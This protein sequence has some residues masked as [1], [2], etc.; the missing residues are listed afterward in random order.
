MTI[1]FKAVINHKDVGTLM[2]EAETE[3]KSLAAANNLPLTNWSDTGILKNL[4]RPVMTIIAAMYDLL[5]DD[6]LTQFD[7]D[8]AKGIWVDAFLAELNTSRKIATFA[9]YNQT[10]NRQSGAGGNITIPKGAVVSTAE[11]VSGTVLQFTVKGNVVMLG[12][13]IATGTIST[14]GT[15]VTGVGTLA[16]VEFAIGDKITAQSQ[17]R[18]IQTITNATTFTVDSAFSSDLS[19]DTFTFKNESVLVPII[20]ERAGAAYN[21]EAGAINIMV[22]SIANIGTTS[23]ASGS[24]TVIARD[25]ETDAASIERYRNI[26]KSMSRAGTAPMYVSL[27]TEVANVIDVF[28]DESLPRGND[29]VDVYYTKT[30]GIPAFVAGTGTITGTTATAVVTGA[31]TKFLTELKK[32]DTVKSNTGNVETVVLSVDSDTQY[33]A[34]TNPSSAFTADTFTFVNTS[35]VQAKFDDEDQKI[36]AGDVEAKVPV[37]SVINWDIILDMHPTDGDI[38]TVDKKAR[39]IIDALYTPGTNWPGV[40]LLRIGHDVQRATI[41]GALWLLK[42]DGV[43]DIQFSVPATFPVAIAVNEKPTK[44]TIAITVNRIT[45]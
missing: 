22:N 33:T 19:G 44:G 10:F 20:A 16:G 5:A 28:V 21:V 8:Q 18:T 27:A 1:N 30:S 35:E 42:D 12:G 6:I 14:T 39:E 34:K 31:N 15:A 43:V 4:Y 25:D 40:P 23:N 41:I 45:L 26:L 32:G 36:L 2:S 9:E 24:Q 11:N 37:A 17:E 13:T 7:V 3:F 38:T 29:T